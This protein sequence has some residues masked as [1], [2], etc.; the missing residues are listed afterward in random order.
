MYCNVW[1]SFVLFMQFL[2]QYLHLFCSCNFY[3]YCD[4]CLV[5]HCSKFVSF[6][7]CDVYNKWTTTSCAVSCYFHHLITITYLPL[8]TKLPRLAPH[9]FHHSIGLTCKVVIRPSSLFNNHYLSPCPL[10]TTLT[11]IYDFHH[12]IGKVSI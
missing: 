12:S 10:F 11:L 1:F 6:L 7:S 5:N 4:A 9:N 2:R 3:K 8:F